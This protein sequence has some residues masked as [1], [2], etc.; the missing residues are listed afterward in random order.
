MARL[1]RYLKC[2]FHIFSLA[3]LSYFL[4]QD[5]INPIIQKKIPR[6]IQD[7]KHLLIWSTL[8]ELKGY[9]QKHLIE[10]KCSSYN[11]YLTTN[12]SLFGDIRYFDGIIFNLQDVSKG[13]QELPKVRNKYQKY[14]F[15]AND[16]ADNYPICDPVYDN[17][18]NW[19]WTYKYVF[20][21]VL[22][23]LYCIISS[24]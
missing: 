24:K 17:F 5:N 11:C 1:L 18:F 16:S 19:T 14:I 21:F 22:L 6:Y 20:L 3:F 9:G 13:T 7:M 12:R 8:P 4:S 2:S 15:A 10:K 23:I